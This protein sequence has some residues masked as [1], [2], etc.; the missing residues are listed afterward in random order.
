MR[1]RLHS[2]LSAAAMGIGVLGCS[3]NPY[4]QQPPLA[5]TSLSSESKSGAA[6]YHTI[7]EDSLTDISRDP[8]DIRPV[9][10]VAARII[11]AAKQSKYA[12]VARSFDWEV[13]VIDDDSARYAIALPGGK[14]LVYTGL[15]P[16]ARNEAGL[17]AI[18]G[19]EVVH[20][21]ARHSAERLSYNMTQHDTLPYTRT[22][23]SEADTIGLLLT[24]EAGYDPHEAVNMW[25]RLKEGMKE[26]GSGLPPEYIAIHPLSDL[27]LAQLDAHMPEARALFEQ[28][29]VAPEAVLPRVEA[30]NVGPDWPQ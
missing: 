22:Q 11:Q 21:L 30:E 29:R 7:L 12:D 26:R 25:V 27:R 10:R 16:L 3:T 18:L 14:L 6:A 23:E 13:T 15:F 20:A 17:A 8:A 24:A 2:V 19:H 28:S 9:E 1:H 5:M 4:S